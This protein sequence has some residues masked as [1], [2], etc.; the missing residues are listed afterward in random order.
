MPPNLAIQRFTGPLLNDA[1][2]AQSAAVE[3]FWH[4]LEEK[5]A[6]NVLRLTIEVFLRL[7]KALQRCPVTPSAAPHLL[8][9]P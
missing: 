9:Q 6:L 8:P 5:H 2:E 1:M 7:G 4:I 3:F